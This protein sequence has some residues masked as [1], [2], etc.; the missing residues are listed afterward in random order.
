MFKCSL[1]CYL[2]YNY[3]QRPNLKSQLH[4]ILKSDEL[5]H[6]LMD[7]VLNDTIFKFYCSLVCSLL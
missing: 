4:D 3:L 2:L 1:V 6:Y 7:Y 5:E